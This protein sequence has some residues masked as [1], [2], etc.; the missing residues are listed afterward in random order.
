MRGTEMLW[1]SHASGDTVAGLWLVHKRSWMKTAHFSWVKML[2]GMRAGAQKHMSSYIWSFN[3]IV[4]YF[5]I[6]MFYEG[7][8]IYSLRRLNDCTVK[9]GGFVKITILLLAGK[10]SLYQIKLLCTDLFFKAMSLPSHTLWKP[11]GSIYTLHTSI[12][13]VNM[14]QRN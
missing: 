2:A 14:V 7:F 10:W 5:G 3:C 9:K 8:N 13:K 11:G 12:M 4:L 1:S 6:K